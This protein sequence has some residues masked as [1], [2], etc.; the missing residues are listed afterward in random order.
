MPGMKMCIRDSNAASL[1]LVKRGAHKV[2]IN[3]QLRAHCSHLFF[4]RGAQVHPRAGANVLALVQA[5]LLRFINR[6]H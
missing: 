3:V 2:Y 1:F 4:S 6:N 5:P